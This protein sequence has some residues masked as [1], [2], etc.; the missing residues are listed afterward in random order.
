[1]RTSTQRPVHVRFARPVGLIA[2]LAGLAALALGLIEPRPR[3]PNVIIVM[4]DTLRADHLS[5]FGYARETSPQI[6]ALARGGVA[7]SSAISQAPYTS[8]SIEALFTGD[9]PSPATAVSTRE[10]PG[11][12][13]TLAEHFRAAGY[14]TAG[15]SG[16]PLVSRA[17]GHAQGFDEF[18][19]ESLNYRPATD[20]FGAALDWLSEHDAAQPFFLYVHCMDV[21]APYA[22]PSS[23]DLWRDGYRGPVQRETSSRY[24]VGIREDG[25]E[26]FERESG[27]RFE[28]RDLARLISLYDASI[29]FFDRVFAAFIRDLEA[30]GQLRDTVVVLVADHGEEFME[31]GSLGH[32]RTLFDHQLRVPLLIMGPGVPAGVRIDE[33]VAVADVMPTVLDLAAIPRAAD[34]YGRS[35][36]SLWRGGQR[37]HTAVASLRPSNTTPLLAVRT[38]SAKLVREVAG[39]SLFDLERDPLEQHAITGEA[40]SREA[41]RGAAWL[42]DR[43][44]EVAS[45]LARIEARASPEGG[46]P[47]SPILSNE[48]EAQLRALGYTVEQ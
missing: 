10:L 23:D 31:H 9:L 8:K 3:Q 29:H 19:M 38:P 26:A 4:A 42:H 41:P 13:E 18:E 24:V 45:R 30:R 5:L 47:Q 35:L 48:I 36:T 34:G 33:P 1:M 22:P 6:T 32:G 15:F 16:N 44:D 27:A 11:W 17:T 7:F 12:R 28:E 37:V 46:V 40:S 14:Q 25:L 21:H 39:Q 2:T 20:L 43:E